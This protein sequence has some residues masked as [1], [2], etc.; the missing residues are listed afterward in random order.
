MT[1]PFSL[2]LALRYL[3]PKRTFVSI[4]TLLSV[5][6]VTLGITVLIVVISVMTGFDRELRNKVL[7]FDAHILVTNRMVIENWRKIGAEIGKTEGVVAWAPFVQGP[8][9]IEMR[10][11]SGARVAPAKMRGIDPDMEKSVTNIAD[12]IVD[13]ELNL[14]G[15]YA[16]LGRALAENLGVGVGDEI[17]VISPTNVGEILSQLRKIE[18]N[19]ND[20]GLLDQLKEFVIPASLTISGIFE[21][22]RFQYDSEFFIVPLYIGQE[23]YVLDDGVQGINVRTTDP[24]LAPTIRDRMEASYLRP[25]L[26]AET[27]IDLNSQLFDAIR[28]E[29]NVMF[30]ILMI[31]IIVAAFSIANTMITVTVQKT[32]EIGI[33]KAMGADKWKIVWVFLAQGMI[34]GFFGNIT[35]VALGMTLV[36][37]RNEFK[38]WLAS[39]L[40]IEIFP[41]D[42]Y[43][44]SQIPAEVIPADV[45]KICISAFVICSLAALIPAYFAARLDPV[46]ALRQDG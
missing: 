34:V 19:P 26:F 9:L 3:K 22:G 33:M 44:F 37:Y 23:L 31:I 27:W 12:Y 32:R 45:A 35:G 10:D 41:A 46:K 4:I 43:Q 24:Y 40:G 14:D 38:E 5:L 6:G 39:T 16:V 29:R 15:D 17:S 7:G 30:I 11:A 18:E 42:V 2:F 36:T 28:L 8:V 13:G 1:L 25:P 21:T 20:K